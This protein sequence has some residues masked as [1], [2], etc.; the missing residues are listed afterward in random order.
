MLKVKPMLFYYDTTFTFNCG[1]S[2]AVAVFPIKK[3]Y[4]FI[5]AASSDGSSTINEY[6]SLVPVIDDSGITEGGQQQPITGG[7]LSLEGNELIAE[8]TALIPHSVLDF[9]SYQRLPSTDCFIVKSQSKV[10]KTEYEK[11]QELQR[12]E[13]KY[14]TVPHGRYFII[15]L[16]ATLQFN[17]LP[18]G[19]TFANGSLSGILEKPGEYVLSGSKNGQLYILYITV[20]EFDR[21]K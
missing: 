12:A 18:Q 7:S 9:T 21:I 8:R 6:Y 13:R 14:L 16:D 5:G 10:A 3:L 2:G 17:N 20:P 19:V 15:S 11:Q 1:T 4:S